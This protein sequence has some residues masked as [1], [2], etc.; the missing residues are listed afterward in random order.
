MISQWDF[1]STFISSSGFFNKIVSFE[2]ELISVDHFEEPNLPL[3]GLILDLIRIVP[4]Q[5]IAINQIRYIPLQLSWETFSCWL[6]TVKLSKNN[7]YCTIFKSRVFVYLYKPCV[8]VN[9]DHVVNSENFIAVW[10]F[11]YLA[12]CSNHSPAG[13][14]LHLRFDFVIEDIFA[15]FILTKIKGIR[16]EYTFRNYVSCFSSHIHPFMI[17]PKSVECFTIE[18]LVRCAYFLFRLFMSYSSAPNRT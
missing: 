2:E 4:F 13:Y 1:I 8:V 11:F 18:L 16:W 6:K 5:K 3:I 7:D 10:P 14:F 17:L 12:F 15:S 9:I